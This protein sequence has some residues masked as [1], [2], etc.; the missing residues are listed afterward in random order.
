M[1]SSWKYSK[2]QCLNASEQLTSLEGGSYN[3]EMFTIFKDT[4][5]YNKFHLLSLFTKLEEYI[6]ANIL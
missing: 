1:G 2:R 3:E 4:K 6:A 5:R